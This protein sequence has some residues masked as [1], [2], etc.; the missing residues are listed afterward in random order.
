LN[1]REARWIK[2]LVAFD[3]T[4]IYYKK[5]KNPINSLS[6]QPDFKDDSELSTTKRQL[7]L[8]FLFKFQKHL[9]DVKSNP[10]KK[11]NIDFNETLLFKSVLSLVGIL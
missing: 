5:A 11:Q 10:I 9:R 1:G 6:R 2:E 3:F 4:I 8:N 7:L